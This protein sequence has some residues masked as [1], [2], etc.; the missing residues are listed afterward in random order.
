VRGRIDISTSA[1]SQTALRI[2]LRAWRL[3]HVLPGCFAS[4]L[5]NPSGF[6]GGSC[7][8]ADSKVTSSAVN[9][10]KVITFLISIV[11]KRGST[12]SWTVSCTDIQPA[13]KPMHN[14]MV[15][16]RKGAFG[17]CDFPTE[18]C[19]ITGRWCWRTSGRQSRN[20]RGRFRSFTGPLTAQ[21]VVIAHGGVPP[22]AISPLDAALFPR[23]MPAGTEFCTAWGGGC[24]EDG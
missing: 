11:P 16:S 14:A 18:I 7:E 8:A 4:V 9:T 3:A 2:N 19:C 24:P 21:T 5:L 15:S 1:L 13:G 23:P 17:S 10:R 12:S 20:G 6:C 22:I